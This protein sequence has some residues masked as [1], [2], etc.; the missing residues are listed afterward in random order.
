MSHTWSNQR[1]YGFLHFGASS[2]CAAQRE[3]VSTRKPAQ[4]NRL[5]PLTSACPHGTYLNPQAV[6]FAKTPGIH[7]ATYG[8]CARCPQPPGLG[9]T[10]PSAERVARC[11][12]VS[13]V[14]VPPRAQ[15]SYET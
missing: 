13:G 12:P 7:K 1:G 3:G 4:W 9:C 5:E 11:T 14:N 2:A 15:C 6:D 8:T 10:T